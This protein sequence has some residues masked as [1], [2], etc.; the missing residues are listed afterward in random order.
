MPRELRAVLLLLPLL[1]WR[2]WIYLLLVELGEMKM[3]WVLVEKMVKEKRSLVNQW[4]VEMRVAVMAAGN[5]KIW[6]CLQKL[7]L[8]RNLL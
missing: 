5:W 7:S 4:V 8:Q 3:I 6:I 2:I 1:Q